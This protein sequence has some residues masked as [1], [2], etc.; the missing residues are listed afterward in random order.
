METNVTQAKQEQVLYNFRNPVR[1]A[2][3]NLITPKA[4]EKNGKAVGDPK[5]DMTIMVEPNSPDLVALKDLC[6]SMAKQNNPGKKL[7]ARRLTQE[8]LDDGGVIEVNMPWSDGTKIADKAKEPNDKGQTKDR[9]FMRGKVIIKMSSKY[10]PALS[11]IENGKVISYDNPDSRAT[12]TSLFY[13]GGWYGPLVALHAYKAQE[14]KPG[15]VSLWV[16]AVCFVKHGEK[17][18]GPRVNAAETFAHYAGSVSTED[19]TAGA[20]DGM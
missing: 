3:A 2:F 19:P 4:Y 8:E 1:A 12:L 13:G 11:G 15:G 9:E 16:N 5:Y 6:I 20:D 17:I 7:V 18:T 10:A 14:G